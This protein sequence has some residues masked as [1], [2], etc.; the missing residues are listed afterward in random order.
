MNLLLCSMC[1]LE[2]RRAAWVDAV[3]G[4]PMEPD[5]MES[6]GYEIDVANA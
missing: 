2:T 1:T 5:K 4:N 6:E 3:P